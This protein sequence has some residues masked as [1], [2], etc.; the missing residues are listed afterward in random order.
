MG[1]LKSADLYSILPVHAGR[2]VML[3]DPRKQVLASS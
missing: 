2:E 3:D 1:L